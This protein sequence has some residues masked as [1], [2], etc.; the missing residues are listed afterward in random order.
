[1]QCFRQQNQTRIICVQFHEKKTM[2]KSVSHSKKQQQATSN[3]N[4]NQQ[5]HQ[6]KTNLQLV[7][8]EMSKWKKFSSISVQ[9]KWTFKI[10]GEP[11]WFWCDCTFDDIILMFVVAIEP[12]E[13]TVA[14]DRQL[15]TFHH[16]SLDASRH[17]K[18]CYRVGPNSMR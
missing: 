9:L 14:D 10:Q 5:Q 12:S 1:M 16:R 13:K 4:N 3:K 11:K 8:N 17:N 6:S 7:S 15:V 18:F 2:E